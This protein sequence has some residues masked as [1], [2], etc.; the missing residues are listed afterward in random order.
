MS[1]VNTPSKFDLEN[2]RL[3]LFVV[4]EQY[5]ISLALPV[6]VTLVALWGQTALAD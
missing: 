2:A 6:S 4:A 1:D 3:N 5:L